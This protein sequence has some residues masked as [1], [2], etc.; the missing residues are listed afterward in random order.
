MQILGNT[1]PL[2]AAEK[3]GIIKQQVPVVEGQLPAEAAAVMAARSQLLEA[4]RFVC[5]R[6][7]TWSANAAVP[8]GARSQAFRLLTPRSSFEHL[9]IPLLGRHQTHN[10]S[11]AVM[12]CEVL[13]QLGWPQIT[14]S[15]ISAGL[16]HTHWPLRFEILEGC[17]TII[18]DAAHNPDSINA[19]C[20]LLHEAEWRERA[21]TLIFAVSADKDAEAMLRCVLPEF[22][23]IVFTRFT[24]NP[25]SL[26]PDSLL[27]TAQSLCSELAV[28]PALHTADTPAAAV[29]LAKSLAAETG[30]V[31]AT[32]SIF[33]AAEI[34]GLLLR[35]HP[36]GTH[37]PPQ[38]TP[39][40]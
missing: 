7:F 40:P 28:S 36:L 11:L 34:R 26:P 22:H 4:P 9:E 6:D 8:P 21:G 3:A 30:Y 19:V 35:D 10:A 37:A 25:R 39:A 13:Q 20:Q 17:P 38:A 23:R 32:G 33:L 5:G 12:T 18:L 24:C 16:R 27:A 29:S 14:Q 2:I 15:T 31:L 1:L